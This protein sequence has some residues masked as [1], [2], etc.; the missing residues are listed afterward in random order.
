[1]QDVLGTFQDSEAQREAIY[2]LATDMM[3]ARRR[4]RPD[5]PRDGGDRRPA[6]GGPGLVAR[7][8]SPPCSSGSRSRSVQRRMARPS[9]AGAVRAPATA[10][11]G[12]AR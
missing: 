6:A 2:A 4:L 10:S 12:A 11:A 3:A 5:D 9:Q 1:M 7:A 8:S